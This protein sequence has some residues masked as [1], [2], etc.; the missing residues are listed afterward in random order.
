MNITTR[1]QL[2]INP[3][4]ETDPIIQSIINNNLKKLK[5]LLKDNDANKLY[6]CRQCGLITP[7]IAAVINHKMEI[8]TYLLQV[9]HVDP[10]CRC[11]NGWT[12]LHYVS[13]AKAPL[14]FVEKLLDEKANPNGWTPMEQHIFTPLQTAVVHDRDDVVKVLLSAGAIVQLLTI[15]HPDHLFHNK[16]MAE[17]IDS[18]ASKGHKLCAK[19]RY[20]LDVEIAVSQEQPEKVFRTF[21]EH[22]LLEDPRNHLTMIEMLF[23]V[24]GKDEEKYR[25]GSIKWLKETKNVNTYITGAVS[26]FSKIPKTHV[27]S[28]IYSIH[29]V[30]CTMEDI[31]NEQSLAIIPQLL[32]Q[33]KKRSDIWAVLL[34]TLYVITQKTKDTNDWDSSFTENLCK[35]VAPFVNDLH[36]SDIRVYTYGIFANLL[37]AEHATDIFTSL[38]ITSV[39]EDILT[40]AGMKMN[41]KL[42][43]GLRRLKSHFSEP[44][45]EYE[46]NKA[47]P[48]SKKKKKRKK[49]KKKKEKAEKPEDPSDDVC[50][51]A[52][53]PA[54]TVAVVESTSNGKSSHLKDTNSSG[55]QPWL[56]L[57]KRWK[58]K[59]EKLVGTDKSKV[60]TIKSLT[61][62][63]DAEFRIAKG[64][65]GTEVFLGLRDDGTE[66]A[67]KRMSKS[68]YQVL[69]NEEGILR[70]PK[71]DHP[72][73]VRY[74][75]AAED[76]NYGYLALQLCEYTLEEHMKNNDGGLQMK[77]NLV[78]DVLYSL[79]VLHCQNPE[80][81]HR[82]VKPQNV[83]IDVNGKARLADFGISR[84]LPKG[85]TTLRT[86]SAGTTG[87][88]ATE[89]LTEE[90][91]IPYKSSTDVQV[92]GMLIYYILSGGQHP[93]GRHFERE[94]N[95]HHGKYSLDHVQDV[96]AKDLIEWMINK[97]PK[98]RPRV[99]ECLSHPFCWLPHKQVEYLVKTGNRAEVAKCREAR[100]EL[101]HSLEECTGSVSFK[102]WKDKFPQELVQRMDGKKKAYPESTLG[103]LRFIRNLHEHYA[104]DAAQVDV[105]ALFPDLFGCVYKFAKTR[106]WNSETPLKEM[107]RRED[108][109]AIFEFP[110]TNTEEHL[111][112]PVQESQPCDSEFKKDETP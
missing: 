101:I 53:D 73:I 59:L 40:S 10:N 98:K 21:S 37:S 71:L 81:L 2:T 89:T 38:G 45:L 106:G 35:T 25:E 57:S 43:E 67:I 41:D 9:E 102:Q 96:V 86:A 84:R 78:Y 52:T 91:V 74:I 87:W 112:A 56:Q 90:S 13:I 68:N 97:E 109:G 108:I 69:K 12:P 80:I 26:R 11:Q 24:S 79:R 48:E 85:Q 7:L 61:Y 19:I 100:E 14:D 46:D 31:P 104:K 54:T 88:M 49:K 66:V 6:P 63:N 1:F 72:C 29:A 75:D 18:F 15:K 64:S 103:L 65:D 22:M 20:F 39:P 70:L 47:K 60:T 107:F 95:I 34:Q 27:K 58:E 4:K 16:K 32:E 77:N 50:A 8:C 17:M 92:A 94:F 93:F 99:E 28:A 33:L 76:D 44:N 36:S 30:F 23:T 55:T 111:S 42:K 5:K 83:L 51:A 82:D 62:V 105:T 110:A 3:P